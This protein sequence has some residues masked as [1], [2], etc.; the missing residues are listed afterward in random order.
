MNLLKKGSFWVV[1]AAIM[2]AGLGL[3]GG[4][5]LYQKSSRLQMGISSVTELK[6]KGSFASILF[7]QSDYSLNYNKLP[8]DKAEVISYFE[9]GDPWA[10][11]G[12]W[13]KRVALQGEASLALNSTNRESANLTYTFPADKDFSKTKFVDF[14]INLSDTQPLE[15]SEIMIGDESL[16]NYFVY[17][18]NPMRVGWYFVEI[19]VSQMLKVAADNPSFDLTKIKKLQ[20]SILARPGSSVTA[21]FDLLRMVNDDAY[22][23]DWQ[24]NATD[25]ISFAHVDGKTNFVAR[26]TNAFVATM[27]AVPGLKDFVYEAKVSPQ[28]TGSSGL[29][30]RGSYKSSKGYYFMLGG[31]DTNTWNLK[32]YTDDGWKDLAKGEISNFSLDKNKFYWLR[33]VAS[34]EDLKVL[35]SLDGNDFTELAAVK[36]S[37]YLS[38]GVGVAVFDGYSYFDDFKVKR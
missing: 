19:P 25:M 18:F 37:T 11:A 5:Y 24:T 38:G 21:N 7:G 27:S 8:A 6:D 23:A 14:W 26:R 36:D 1:V 12:F 29:F 20:I 10:G 32:I 22:L 31:K 2:I 4:Y 16:K 33:A 13:D 30:F 17:S 15:K 35:I 9:P 34:G 28:T 3:G